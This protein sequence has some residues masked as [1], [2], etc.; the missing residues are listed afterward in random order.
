MKIGLKL[1]PLEC[2]QANDD[3]G[4]DA[5]T[6]DGYNGIQNA[7]LKTP[8]SIFVLWCTPVKSPLYIFLHTPNYR[9]A[10]ICRRSLII[11]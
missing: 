9:H 4:I 10:P 3:R 2:T 6:S 8:R 5:R 11:L 1:K 7:K